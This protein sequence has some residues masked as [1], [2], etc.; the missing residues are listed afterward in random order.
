MLSYKDAYVAMRRHEQWI[1]SRLEHSE[2][3]VVVAYLSSNTVD[4]FLSVLACTDLAHHQR[5][6]RAQAT[7]ALLNTRWTTAEIVS[8]LNT[9]SGRTLLLYGEGFREKASECAD[10]LGGLSSIAAIPKLSNT[11]LRFYCHGC[12]NQHHLSDWLQ[13]K[14][15]SPVEK[16]IQ[17]MSHHTRRSK[18]A[19]GR[20]P[21]DDAL[22]VFT[23]GTTGGAKGVRLGHK[24]LWIQALAKL[25]RPCGYDR[26]TKMLATTVPLFHVGGLSST[27]AVF[28]AGGTW[29]LPETTTTTTTTGGAGSRNSFN[30]TQVCKCLLHSTVAPNTLVVVPAMLHALLQAIQETATTT[31]VFPQ[32]RLLLI[33]GQSVS[34]TMVRRVVQHF[35]NARIVQTYACTEAASSL[36]FHEVQRQ[37]KVPPTPIAGDCVGLPPSHVDLQLYKNNDDDKDKEKW[38]PIKEPWQIGVFGTR[39][40]H[41][42]NGYWSRDGRLDPTDLVVTN[43]LGFRDERGRFYFCGRVKD[44]IR[45]GGETVLASEVERVLLG[46]PTVSECAVF[47]L[48]DDRFG[49]TVCVAIVPTAAAASSLLSLTHLRRYCGE[50]GLATYKRPRRVFCVNALPRNSS[51]KVL[52]HILVERFK[53]GE[54]GTAIQSR[55]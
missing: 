53:H 1:R 48:P 39:G 34:S 45:T 6:Q 41:I 47:A 7:V 2:P 43:D 32:V 20:V 46:H 24:A 35:P 49:E 30:P 36:T 52:K 28:L 21:D 25:C 18:M 11:F 14:T 5:Q 27:L 15:D 33:G 44:V 3:V 51:G 23:S 22:I 9:K 10:R 37:G 42:M 17:A 26:L 13:H 19:P 16:E 8:A 40:P 31:T 38:Q 4:M 50:Q 55:L 12:N 29:I 54:R